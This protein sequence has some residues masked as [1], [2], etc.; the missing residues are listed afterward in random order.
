MST[1]EPLEPEP[2]PLIK[3]WAILPYLVIVF[4][5]AILCALLV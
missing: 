5:S 2:E 4:G 1:G 3:A